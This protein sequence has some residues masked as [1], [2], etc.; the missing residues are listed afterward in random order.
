MATEK[1][2]LD[3]LA[4]ALP[5]DLELGFYHISTPPAASS[6][7]FS[8]PPGQVAAKTFC[9]SHFVAV[10]LLA[11]G[12]LETE[13]LGF[14]IEVLIFTTQTLTTV[15]VSKADSTGHLHL[16]NTQ[17]DSPSAI[18]AVCT[19][20]L[21]H[22]IR[23][24]LHG[25][26]VVLSLF[27][28]SQ[29]QYLFPG[30]IENPTKHVL[31]DRQLIKWW[32]RT[33]DPILLEYRP[34]QVTSNVDGGSNTRSRAYLIIP[35]CDKL[36]TRAFFPPSSTLDG[37]S[38]WSD[39][40]P[41]DLIIQDS[42]SPPRCLIP[43]FPDDPKARFL[44]DLDSEISDLDSSSI[45]EWRSV[46]SLDQFWEM[47]S[48][49][50]ECSAGRLVGFIWL[51]FTPPNREEE[52]DLC[53]RNGAPEHAVQSAQAIEQLPTP[54]Q[55]QL[56]IL[57]PIPPSLLSDEDG[58]EPI[59]AASPPSSSSILPS[60]NGPDQPLRQEEGESTQQCKQEEQASHS[61]PNHQQ[62]PDSLF[63][64]S[65]QTHPVRW[66]IESRGNLILTDEKY[67]H[68]M[69]HLLNS[70]FSTQDLATQ[71]TLSWISKASTLAG[72]STWGQ[73]VIG[74]K[75]AMQREQANGGRTTDSVN[76][77]VNILTGMRK[78]R[79]VDGGGAVGKSEKEVAAEAASITPAAKEALATPKLVTLPVDLIK[80]KRKA[81]NTE[82]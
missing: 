48:Y 80:K 12:T 8:A 40:Y 15:F 60:T 23:Q 34:A 29:N 78:K 36:E 44:D 31:D 82:D 38:R 56:Q 2:I 46:Q 5:L 35:G 65:A 7:L 22:L 30:S 45:G 14:A 57:D 11:E 76:A 41:L 9:E 32:C 67:S 68:L 79:K 54:N 18:K 17:L 66:P 49:R 24:R 19:T 25:S 28:R 47:M 6:A 42:S 77:N 26:R 27:A 73:R 72:V 62:S 50:Q 58:L 64:D 20:V 43:R 69:T 21:S 51:I 53:G 37:P 74:R 4:D 39:S 55:S 63:Y 52:A 13:L 75:A 33:L 71:S 10:S 59:K 61:N 70:D 16:V 3:A 81:T 1:A